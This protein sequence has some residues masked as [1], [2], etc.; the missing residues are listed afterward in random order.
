MCSALA[1][2]FAAHSVAV[3]LLTI[4]GP[5]LT[6]IVFALVPFHCTCTSNRDLDF[7]TN[8]F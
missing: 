2:F 6:L 1:R 4:P 8:S 5:I 7:E 3:S